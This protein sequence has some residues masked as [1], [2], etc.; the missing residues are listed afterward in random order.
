MRLLAMSQ[1]ETA[2]QKGRKIIFLS[3][4]SHSEGDGGVTNICCL[5]TFWDQSLERVPDFNMLSHCRMGIMK[6]IGSSREYLLHGTENC[7]KILKRFMLD[8]APG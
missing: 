1:I 8:W 2:K 4:R 7:R 6:E 3:F 5:L